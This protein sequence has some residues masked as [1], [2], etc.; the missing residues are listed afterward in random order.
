MSSSLRRIGL[1][2]RTIRYLKPEQL[3]RRIAFKLFPPSVDR[4]ALPECGKAM[5]LRTRFPE[6]YRVFSGPDRFRFLNDERDFFGWNDPACGKLWLYNLHYFDLLRQADLTEG[7][8]RQWIARWIAENPPFSGNGWEPYPISLRIVNWIKWAV[9]GHP[10][11]GAASASLALQAR[12]LSRRI[13]RHLLAN[14]LLANAKA[15]VFAGLFF[16]GSEADE[17]LSAGLDIYREQLPEQILADGGHFERSPMY[18]SIILEDLL[19]LFNLGV[20]LPL[21]K[22]VEKM[23]IWLSV[24]TGPDGKIAHFNDAADGIALAPQTLFAYA[25]RL[26]IG[27]PQECPKC[28]DLPQ[29]GYARM[30]AGEWTAICDGAPIGPDYQPGHAHADTLTFELWHGKTR[31]MV[32]SGTGEYI[33]TPLRREQRG[34]AGHNTLTVDGANSS[35]VWGAHRVAS[36]ARIVERRFADN[37]FSAAHDGFRGMTHRREWRISAAGV[38]IRDRVGGNGVH[39]VDMY[40]HLSPSAEVENLGG[41]VVLH[42]DGKSL[43]LMLP[44]AVEYTVETGHCSSEFGKSSN[45][46]VV[47]C[48]YR[49]NLPFEAETTINMRQDI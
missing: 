36:R 7:E 38:N 8:G 45:H 23:L 14:H 41:R 17:W 4:N 29:T 34:T 15:L 9:S 44:A 30:S 3:W 18:H 49:G 25:G 43:V 19:D 1:Y 46:P 2:W 20:P 13:E 32:D 31:M 47:H 40:W 39:T 26:G 27:I 10:L 42:S 5:E 22:T 33:D 28:L 6:G 35:E 48:R 16:S 24:M 12:F 11:D 37:S 21:Q